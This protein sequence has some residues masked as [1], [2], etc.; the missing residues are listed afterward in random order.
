MSIH[1]FTSG[2][3]FRWKDGKTCVMRLL[4]DG[5]INIEQVRTGAVQI[6]K[7][8]DFV[9]ALFNGELIFTNKGA[10]EPSKSNSASAGP[11]RIDLSDGS[12]T[13]SKWPGGLNAA[14]REKETDAGGRLTAIQGNQGR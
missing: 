8:H 12:I 5:E 7:T 10:L 4:P 1:R 11:D 2:Q 3:I 13:W 9:M 6:V 14:P